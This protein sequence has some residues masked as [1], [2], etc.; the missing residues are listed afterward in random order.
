MNI[1]IILG[2]PCPAVIATNMRQ[3]Q[4]GKVRDAAEELY[5]VR[6]II[7]FIKIWPKS[8]CFEFAASVPAHWT[9]ELLPEGTKI[10]FTF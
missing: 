9:V 2:N 8:N 7:G 3:G 4:L 1:E 6:Q 5:L 10:T